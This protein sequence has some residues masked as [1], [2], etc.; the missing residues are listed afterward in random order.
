MSGPV[1][2]K[3][4]DPVINRLVVRTRRPPARRRRTPAARHAARNVRKYL[5]M[6]GSFMHHDS[7]RQR[8]GQ[9]WRRRRDNRR[10]AP[11]RLRRMYIDC[12]YGQLHLTTAY[13]A[14]GGF[15]EASPIVFL[16]AE[17]GSGADFSRCAALLG[18]DRSIYA[19]DLPGSGGSDAPKAAW[20][21]PDSPSRS[22]TSSNSCACRRVDLVGCGRGALVAYELAT[23]RPRKSGASSSPAPSSRQRG[24]RPA[25]APA[26]RRSGPGACRSPPRPSPPRSA[27][28]STADLGGRGCPPAAE[29][30][31]RDQHGR[32]QWQRREI[33]PFPADGRDREPRKQRRRRLRPEHQEVV[34]R[35]RLD[36][37][38]RAGRS[39][40]ASWSRR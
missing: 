17:D 1:A 20:R 11:A 24:A 32:E 9:A 35:L 10:S 12:R 34:Q 33:Q 23:T 19:P 14:S 28:S 21:S 22:S 18:T 26:F 38:A 39:W 4:H 2:G 40:S 27:P 37:L 7:G 25:D 36:P 30:R 31:S 5:G 8:T 3:R 15:D 6:T 29:R 16:H 13:P